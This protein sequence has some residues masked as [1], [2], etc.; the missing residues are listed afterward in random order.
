ML[1]PYKRQEGPSSMREVWTDGGRSNAAPLQ[2]T[3]RTEHH[4]GGGG[5]TQGAAVLRPYNSQCGL[6]CGFSR[7]HSHFVGFSAMY[8]VAFENS[9]PSRN[10]RSK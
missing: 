9:R 3:R 8:L 4:E 10:T 1:R 5:R 2:T 7:S 6:P